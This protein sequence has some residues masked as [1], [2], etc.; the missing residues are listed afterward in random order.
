MEK[1]VVELRESIP[2]CNAM[3]S[4]DTT[5]NGTGSNNCG[6]EREYKNKKGKIM[7]G[8]PSK[9]KDINCKPMSAKMKAEQDLVQVQMLG[10][11]FWMVPKLESRMYKAS[12]VTKRGWFQQET[13]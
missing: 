13:C 4:R 9:D 12:Q 5:N 8:F 3:S 6:A 2:K 7:N 1:K 10:D 11:I